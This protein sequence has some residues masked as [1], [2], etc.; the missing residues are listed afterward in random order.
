MK[1]TQ[2]SD[3]LGAAQ[4]SPP[5]AELVCHNLINI[6]RR[7]S[8]HDAWPAHDDSYVAWD[9][10][11]SLPRWSTAPS[12]QPLMQTAVLAAVDILRDATRS[13]PATS[14]NAWSSRAYY[15]LLRCMQALMTEVRQAQ[16]FQC[17]VLAA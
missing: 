10:L 5:V 13:Q 2:Q 9:A 7:S 12:N 8:Q 3:L 17:C 11:G 16:L 6:L 15:K 4:I 14:C 1:A